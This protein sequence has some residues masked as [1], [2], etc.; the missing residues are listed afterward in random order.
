MPP[1]P[2]Y[3]ASTHLKA[4]PALISSKYSKSRSLREV[5][6]SHENNY[7]LIRAF[8]AASVIYFHSFHLVKAD[9]Y[10]DHLSGALSPITQ[11]GGLA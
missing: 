9:G 1:L 10:A 8:L 5:I 4:W 6:E 2:V 11:V 7:T 3:P